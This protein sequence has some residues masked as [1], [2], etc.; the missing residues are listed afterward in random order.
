[1]VMR[2]N[3]F[4]ADNTALSRRKADSAIVNGR[5]NVNGQ[6]AILG[7]EVEP[8]DV[9]LLDGVKIKPASKET[10]VVLLN[11]PVGY[12][13][14]KRGQGSKTVYDLLPAAY[15]ELN[16]AGRLDKDSS[17]L[18]V[19]TNSGELL[20]ELAHPGN[21]KEK[22][23]EVI[24][25]KELWPEDQKKLLKGVNIGDERP[26]KF[27][28]MKKTS[29]KSF[30]IVLSEGRNRQVRRSFK[31]LGYEVVGLE[32]TRLGSYSLKDIPS[33]KFKTTQ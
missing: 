6:K 18:V 17:G 21:N 32:R 26:S 14:S 9:I 4:L 13:S 10:V 23:Y 27:K 22:V 20:N 1:M 25:D 29:S 24:L 19:L 28:R 31:T 30:E 12:V 7:I 5:V 8:R 15:S 11:K 3:K 33:G 2:L 16:I